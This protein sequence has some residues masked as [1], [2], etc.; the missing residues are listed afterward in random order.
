MNANPNQAKA[1]FL[2]AVE[3]HAPEQW[4]AFL[5]QACAGRPELRGRVEELLQAHREAGTD[6]Q[7]TSAEGATPAPCDA[8]NSAERPGSVIGPYRL[9]QQLGEGGMGA[10]FLAEQTEPVSRQVALKI[11]KPGMDS[12]QVIARFE[13]ERQA[14]AL[15]DHPNIARVLDAGTIPGEPGCVSAG[16][17]YFVMELVQGV[18]FTR[19]C[20]EHRL[21][22]RQRLEL[23]VPVCQAVQHAHQ[24][25]IIHRDLKPSNVLVTLYDGQPVPKVIDFGIAKATT[26]ELTER[27]RFTE[28][29]QVVGT[30]EYMSPEQADLNNQDIDTRSDIYSLGVLLY[31]LLTGTTPLERKRLREAG[32]LEVLRLIREEEPPRPSTR[33]STTDELPAIAASR[34]LEPKKL[35]GQMRGEL[36]WIV[37]KALEKDRS[38]R[39]ET[40]NAFAADVLRYLSDEPVQ[41]CP[42]SAWYRFRKYARRNRVV[43]TTTAVVVAALLVGTGVSAWWAVQ[44]TQAWTNETQARAK[45]RNTQTVLDQEQKEKDQ[46]RSRIDREIGGSLVEL[47]GHH[48]TA[49]AAGP[50]DT[51][52]WAAL[53]EARKRAETLMAS[54]LADPALVQKVQELLEKLKPMEA[55]RRMLARLE[56]LRFRSTQFLREGF[57]EPEKKEADLYL[58]AFR[59]YGIPLEALEIEEAA[60]RIRD[61]AIK[62]EL[63]AA[64]N[65]LA[66]SNAGPNDKFLFIARGVVDD[67]WRRDYFD[68]RLANKGPAAIIALARRPEALAQP[69]GTISMLVQA[70]SMSYPGD[71]ETVVDLLRKAQVRHPAD[72]FINYQLASRLSYSTNLADR[73]EAAGYARIVLALS[74]DN[75]TILDTLGE[76]LYRGDDLD[77]AIEVFRQR[78][79]LKRSAQ[80]DPDNWLKLAWA[81]RRQGNWDG[82]EA[83]YRELNRDPVAYNEHHSA[84][85][86]IGMVLAE[87]GAND[88]AIAIFKEEIRRNQA[89]HWITTKAYAGLGWA[90]EEQDKLDEARAAYQESIL[91]SHIAELSIYFDTFSGP[92]PN[93]LSGLIRVLQKQGVPDP[94]GVVFRDISRLLQ[95]KPLVQV[96][97]TVAGPAMPN[98][99]TSMLQLTTLRQIQGGLGEPTGLPRYRIASL[100][101][102]LGAEMTRQGNPDAVIAMYEEAEKLLP[103]QTSPYAWGGYNRHH[104]NFGQALLQKDRLDEAID[105]LSWAVGWADADRDLPRR[106]LAEALEKK[107]QFDKAIKTLE[108]GIF[109]RPSDA[110]IHYQIG[111]ILARQDKRT[112]AVTAYKEALRWKPDFADA[113]YQLGNTLARQDKLGEAVAEYRQVLRFNANQEGA[114]RDLGIALARLREWDDAIAVFRDAVRLWPKDALAH[115]HLGNALAARDKLNDAIA[116]Y[117]EALLLKPELAEAQA[118]LKSA[119]ARQDKPAEALTLLVEAVHRQPED[120]QAY[121]RLGNALAR[122]DKLDAAAFAYC[123][124][125]QLRPDD[126][127]ILHDLG[128]ALDRQ[129][130]FDEALVAYGEAVRLLPDDV[131]ARYDFGYALSRQGKLDEAV[132]AF[133]EV[134]RRK[135]DFAEAHG[136]LGIALIR[137]AKLG[138]PVVK[139]QDTLTRFQQEKRA[140]ALAAY[141]KA[142]QLRPDD[143]VAYLNL[144][145]GLF[146][147]G[148][149]DEGLAAYRFACQHPADEALAHSRLAA[150]LLQQEK[151][152]EAI[153][154]GREALRRRPDLAEAHLTLDSALEQMKWRNEAIASQWQSFL[155]HPDDPNAYTNLALSLLRAGRFDEAIQLKSGADGAQSLAMYLANSP[156]ADRTIAD[157]RQ[158]LRRRPDSASLCIFLGHMLYRRGARDEAVTM[159]SEWLDR[160]P[161]NR[162]ILIA[163]GQMYQDQ[164][165]VYQ[166]QPSQKDKALADFAKATEVD[167]KDA[168][169]WVLRA[170]LEVQLNKFTEAVDHYSQAIQLK[171][172]MAFYRSQRGSCYMRLKQ[173]NEAVADYTRAIELTPSKPSAYFLTQLLLQRGDAFAK[174]EQWD[175]AAADFAEATKVA[176]PYNAFQ[177]WDKRGEFHELRGE[178]DKAIA[179]YAEGMDRTRYAPLLA[180]QV[181]LLANCSDEKVRD[182]ARA[183]KVLQDTIK[184]FNNPDLLAALGTAHYRA[185]DFK[186]ALETLTRAAA[187]PGQITYG[188]PSFVLAMTQQKLGHKD[189]ARKWYGQA[190]QTL[191]QVEQ[192]K[193]WMDSNPLRYAELHRFQAEVEK[194]LGPEDAGVLLSRGRASAQKRQYAQALADF[195][196]ATEAAPKDAEAW[197]LRSTMHGTLG[198]YEQAVGSMSRAVELSPDTVKYWNARAVSYLGLRQWDKAIA[199]L[200][201][202]IALDQRSPTNL[203]LRG[204]AYVAKEEL[205]KALA[206]YSEGLKRSP[207]DSYALAKRANLYVRL[208]QWGKA[209]DDYNQVVYRNPRDNQSRNSLAWL[210]ATCPDVKVRAPIVALGLAKET[211]EKEPT[212]GAAWTTLGVA[213]YSAGDWKEALVALTKTMD[214]Q[215]GGI[216]PA[217][218]FLAMTQQKLGHKDEARK[219]YDKAVEWMEKDQPKDEE[220]RRFQKEAAEVLGLEKTPK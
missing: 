177:A 139:D 49:K 44:A 111:N 142:V 157:C 212:W 4:P 123:A 32:F 94:A 218:F 78:L 122:Q 84:R 134:V 220:L 113:H 90:L 184:M 20:D 87:T 179:V 170:E 97:Q 86:G 210:L 3:K 166:N 115:Y 46:Q 209:R 136:N 48:N 28:V 125:M 106:Q 69:P 203:Y 105:Y 2:E 81:L 148:N 25:G 63:V 159:F 194:L 72:L 195:T 138:P 71:W 55:D 24:K 40:A 133:K 208:G 176:E 132:A 10:V 99:A 112:D 128:K 217:Y 141:R 158:A 91:L 96:A 213:H 216:G 193:Y 180:K 171:P 38:R 41:A 204:D 33:L 77:R 70:L 7:R 116:A 168:A 74:P 12:R 161:R 146:Q 92:T 169:T 62:E 162:D 190:L 17:P 199:D 131:H 56:D 207:G 75:P 88:Q 219:W 57:H 121:H 110:E 68:A 104:R 172:D 23:F 5:D 185:G 95:Q 60:R 120:G 37:M 51:K 188:S 79:R 8:S 59:E 76:V 85:C 127:V 178:W 83:V 9:L 155:Q 22:P 119:L 160:D 64:L 43:L 186:A 31:E 47:A 149:F 61:S 52:Q 98:W 130:K 182:P 18:P 102:A 175:K 45:E 215:R 58:A 143:A 13:A 126:G 1:I 151:L 211:I 117:K 124:A 174:S 108:K 201:R 198:Q 189:E 39:Y 67:P 205:D 153:A 65:A 14:L 167:P 107:G 103:H 163:R 164:F 147:Q 196:K 129:E 200:T 165:Q 192:N 181:W 140:E 16:R 30:L 66:G 19:Y 154:A 93:P 191:G 54:E 34:G 53:R 206:D 42:P 89:Y 152:D 150:A 11:I 144:S 73:R 183:I 156:L 6:P 202:A 15:M 109:Q 114:H 100:A 118:G 173:W 27:T 197:Y 50:T 135:P 80:R 187:A 101:L 214:L 137:Q 35:S 82:A 36:D 145:Q 21:T 26:P 29:G